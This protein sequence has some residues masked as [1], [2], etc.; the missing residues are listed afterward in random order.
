ML[1]KVT[2][3][4]ALCDRFPRFQRR[5]N[6]RLPLLDQTGAEQVRLIR[7]FRALGPE[8]RNYQK[9]LIA[10]LL[11]INCVASGLGWTG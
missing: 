3:E 6:R 8:S 5:L 2:G 9:K 10:L 1:I 4:K 11:S 7:E